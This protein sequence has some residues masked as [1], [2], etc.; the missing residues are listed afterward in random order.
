MNSTELSERT[1]DPIQLIGMSFY[2]VPSTAERAKEH[3]LNVFEFYGLGRG[4]VLG[5]ADFDS[6]FEAFT[7]FSPSAMDMLWAKSR[8]KADPAQVASAHL[9]AAYVFADDTFGG[10]DPSILSA[11]ADAAFKVLNSVPVGRHA[12]F[13]GYRK[14]DVPSNPVHAAYLASILLREL[15]GGVHIDAVHEVGISAAQAAYLQ[16]PFIFKLHGYGEDDVPTVTLELEGKKK[17][18]EELTTAAVATFFEVLSDE[19]RE[20]LFEGTMAMNDAL[21]SP[22]SVTA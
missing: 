22:V 6:V 4:G 12:L 10:I 5:D 14:F 15:R 19:E 20:A 1:A 3:G 17:H 16:D 18:A 11:F 13:D 7:F 21:K 9:R 2:F 8:E